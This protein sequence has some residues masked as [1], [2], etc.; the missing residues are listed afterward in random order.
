M[1]KLECNHF[2]KIFFKVLGERET[3]KSPDPWV[4]WV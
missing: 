2:L 1:N 3:D 4:G